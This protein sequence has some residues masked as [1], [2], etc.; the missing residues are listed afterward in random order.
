[1]AF[2][3]IESITDS[4]DSGT[5]YTSV[6]M[7][8]NVDEGDLL[9]ILTAIYNAGTATTP[10]GWTKLYGTGNITIVY[11][12]VA[13]GTEGGTSVTIHT[14]GYAN[15]TSKVMR[16]K[17]WDGN[18]D[19]VE[20]TGAF[21]TNST[22]PNP[23]SETASWGAKDNLWI[24]CLALDNS[25]TVSSYPTNY[26]NGE[27]ATNNGATV[28]LAKRERNIATEDPGSYTISSSSYS[29]MGT[30]VIKPAAAATG[31][32]MQINIGD[33]FKEVEALKINIGDEWKNVIAV[34]QNIGDEWKDV[35]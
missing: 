5:K 34:K 29:W 33:S 3:T 23:P 14:T 25:R 27:S 6:D 4:N 12:K 2:P 9:I 15:T 10:T 24:A 30:I 21:N 26:S 16:I 31:T 32:N 18:I 11:A 1:M 13:T 8:A 22:T 17:N 19:G 28:G 7:P 35:F 20:A